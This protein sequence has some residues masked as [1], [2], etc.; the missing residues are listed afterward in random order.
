[1]KRGN[2]GLM[3]PQAKDEKGKEKKEKK[4]FRCTSTE[5]FHHIPL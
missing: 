5:S 1:M 4:D 2:N 3:K